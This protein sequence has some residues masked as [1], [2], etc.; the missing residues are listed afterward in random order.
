LIDL[1]CHTTCSD[2]TL[3]PAAL[4][5]HAREAGVHVLAITDHDTIEAYGMAAAAAAEKEITLLCGVELSTHLAG[6]SRSVHLLGYFPSQPDAAF[7]T[8]L[9][10]LQESREKRNAALLARLRELG[11]DIQ[12]SDVR[13]LAQRQVGRPHFAA[14]LLQKGCV[15]TMKE[16]FDR[17]LGEGAAA[18]VDRDEPSLAE[19]LERVRSTGGLTSL[20]HPVRISADWQEVERAIATYADEGLD[21]VECFHSEHAAEDTRRLI[22]LAKT[23]HLGVTGGSDFHGGTKPE[24]EIGT[25]RKGNL[26]VPASVMDVFARRYPASGML[27]GRDGSHENEKTTKCSSLP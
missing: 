15:T 1:H 6:C 20:A 7:C 24:V 23:Y 11:L 5:D 12:W 27:N 18:W 2:G 19:A 3:S 4:L 25:G 8:W 14:V 17:Y 16:A 21:A 13:A 10:E 22:A 26:R 9:R